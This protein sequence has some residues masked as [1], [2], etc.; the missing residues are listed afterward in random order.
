MGTARKCGNVSRMWSWIHVSCWAICWCSD[1]V[2][3]NA[4]GGK[5]LGLMLMVQ[6]LMNE[7]QI[8]STTHN[9]A[10]IQ[11]FNLYT[12]TLSCSVTSW[13]PQN[14]ITRSFVLESWPGA[15]SPHNQPILLNMILTGEIPCEVAV[16]PGQVW[17]CG[18]TKHLSSAAQGEGK[19]ACLP[20]ST[21]RTSSGSCLHFCRAAAMSHSARSWF[22][23]HLH[24]H[25]HLPARTHTLVKSSFAQGRYNR[26]PKQTHIQDLLWQYG[27]HW[28]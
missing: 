14:P 16:L 7:W 22:P 13:P 23:H 2:Q 28:V 27:F 18:C 1:S 3:M 9:P 10:A 19:P 17:V 26:T 5:A 11:Q 25:I 8:S 6:M 15:I 24:S 20:V 4:A 12:G 21:N